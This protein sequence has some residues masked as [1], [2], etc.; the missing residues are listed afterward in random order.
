MSTPS[1]RRFTDAAVSLL[2]LVALLGFTT[3]YS[4]S[5]YYSLSN[6]TRCRSISHEVRPAHDVVAQDATLAVTAFAAAPP[7]TP[8][9]H[10]RI[11]EP[12]P[13]AVQRLAL[14]ASPLRRPPPALV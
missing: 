9:A 14:N 10:L 8:I 5:P 7:P 11:A 4:N 1:S 3:V 13:I 2:L 12:R 6:P